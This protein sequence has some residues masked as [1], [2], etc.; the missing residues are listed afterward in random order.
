MGIV[1]LR[2][3]MTLGVLFNYAIESGQD[4]DD[5]INRSGTHI[6]YHVSDKRVLLR[7]QANK[8]LVE[9]PSTILNNTITTGYLRLIYANDELDLIYEQCDTSNNLTMGLAIGIPLALFLVMAA[10]VITLYCLFCRTSDDDD[11]QDDDNIPQSLVENA[12]KAEPSA[13]QRDKFLPENF[14]VNQFHYKGPLI[15]ERRPAF[16][17]FHDLAGDPPKQ[18]SAEDHVEFDPNMNEAFEIGEGVEESADVSKFKVK[19]E[20]PLNAHPSLRYGKVFTLDSRRGSVRLARDIEAAA[21]KEL[22]DAMVKSNYRRIHSK[23]KP[24]NLGSREAAKKRGSREVAK[25]VRAKQQLQPKDDGCSRETS[26]NKD[27][28]KHD[29]KSMKHAST[30]SKDVIIFDKTQQTTESAKAPSARSRK[31]QQSSKPCGAIESAM[32]PLSATQPTMHADYTR[33]VPGKTPSSRTTTGSVKNDLSDKDNDNA[34]TKTTETAKSAAKEKPTE[35]NQQPKT[36]KSGF[37]PKTSEKK[38]SQKRDSSKTTTSSKKVSSNAVKKAI[39]SDHPNQE[40]KS[41]KKSSEEN[42]NVKNETTTNAEGKMSSGKQ[43]ISVTL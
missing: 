6:Y 34:Q 16:I 18:L 5:K 14:D 8:F 23:E 32:L 4:I 12:R 22:H 33:H 28:R 35:R 2:M 10:V 3:L 29:E 42:E 30:P 40:R 20:E 37:Q 15:I 1:W 21:M 11:Q 39:G 19:A 24:R 43:I 25:L 31:Q 41:Q 26:A 17:S 7:A 27:D 9:E 13:S 38:C 36:T